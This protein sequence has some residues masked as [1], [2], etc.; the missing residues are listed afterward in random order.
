MRPKRI[1]VTVTVSA[2]GGGFGEQAY[3]EEKEVSSP[4]SS[5]CVSVLNNFD[6]R[7]PPNPAL[8]R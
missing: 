1:K 8:S 2:G 6:S 3:S 5:F 7:K 4:G